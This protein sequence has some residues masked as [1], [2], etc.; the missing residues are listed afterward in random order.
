[1]TPGDAS[2]TAPF[3]L[4]AER[5]DFVHA[6]VAYFDVSFTKCHKLMGF[7]TGQ[8]LCSLPPIFCA[9]SVLIEV[10]FGNTGNKEVLKKKE[11]R[12]REMFYSYASNVVKIN[13]IVRFFFLFVKG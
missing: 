2:F 11:K 12:K 3:K 6:L 5:D 10:P 8:H 9:F 7:S 1:M 13:K 4:I